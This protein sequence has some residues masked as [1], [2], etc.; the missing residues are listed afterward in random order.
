MKESCKPAEIY[1]KLKDKYDEVTRPGGMK[2]IY[3]KLQY[4][5]SKAAKL[6]GNTLTTNI[7]DQISFLENMVTESHSFVRS[8]I[9]T[10]GRPPTIIL[11]NDEQI[12]DIK[13]L[14]CSGQTV[15]GVDKTFML[16][17]MH[18]TVTCY[19]QLTVTRTTTEEPPL[20]VGP[21][22]IHDNSDYETFSQFF[23]LLKLKLTGTEVTKLVVGTD[24]EKAL[25]KAIITEFPH[26]THVLCTRHLQENV[27]QQLTDDGVSLNERKV[28][29]NKI[30][31]QDGIVGATDNIC[32]EYKC[33]ELEKY[34]T[35][36]ADK[37]V[38]YFHRRLK[39]L[40]KYKVNEPMRAG[41]IS[42]SWTNNNAVHQPRPKTNSKLGNEKST[43]VR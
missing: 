19:K 24:D 28:I 34:C 21:I 42:S 29:L 14:C 7:A 36:L 20:F 27:R 5:K 2:T 30:F 23:H 8:V 35:N 22:F 12:V 32:F 33:D 4:E 17:K 38:I 1:L 3:N 37:F 40:L 15:L 26:S 31:G 25:V 41:F 9:R 11:Y 10:S 39:D 16:C 18:V 43:R 13:N 6:D